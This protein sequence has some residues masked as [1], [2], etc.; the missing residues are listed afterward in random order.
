MFDSPL[1]TS[2]ISCAQTQFACTLNDM[3]LALIGCSHQVLYNGGGTIRRSIINHQY[4]K[5]QR[6]IHHCFD[7]CF[8]IFLLIVG[9]NNY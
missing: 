3:Q 7:D 6:K 5:L 2:D 1:K 8:D 9:W 4:M